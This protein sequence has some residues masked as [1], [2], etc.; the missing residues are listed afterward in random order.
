[1][2]LSI[3]VIGQRTAQADDYVMEVTVANMAGMGLFGASL[4]I[5]RYFDPY[6]LPLLEVGFAAAMLGGPTVHAL[7][8]NPGRGLLSLG[9]RTSTLLVGGLLGAASQLSSSGNGRRDTNLAMLITG[10]VMLTIIDGV[11][12]PDDSDGAPRP[13]M[14]LMLRF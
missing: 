9:L 13:A 7:Y 3:L 4:A 14:N 5:E 1:M 10:W 6:P 11:L 12:V 2:S 8:G